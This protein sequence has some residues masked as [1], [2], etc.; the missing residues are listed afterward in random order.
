MAA[1][2]A[3]I[4]LLRLLE[5]IA[6]TPVRLAIDLRYRRP[7]SKCCG[8]SPEGGREVVQR[9]L[10]AKVS[11]IGPQGDAKATGPVDPPND[12]SR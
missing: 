3:A 8:K 11:A 4:T 5:N 9:K 12:Q 10:T 2:V 7:R 6:Q 1:T